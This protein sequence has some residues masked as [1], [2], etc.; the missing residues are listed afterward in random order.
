MFYLNFPAFVL[1][2]TSW[3]LALGKHRLVFSQKL[4]TRKKISG[5][6]FSLGFPLFALFFSLSLQSSLNSGLQISVTSVSPTIGISFLSKISILCLNLHSSH[7]GLESAS[8][9]VARP[10]MQLTTIFASFSQESQLCVP[11]YPVLE[12][13]F[14]IFFP[15]S[16]LFLEKSKTGSNHSV[17]QTDRLRAF[18][19][20]IFAG[21]LGYIFS[22]T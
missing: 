13:L 10:L 16:W 4:K 22:D 12:Q 11:C 5:V 21:A 9:Q 15:V 1:Y 19:W 2:L 6:L 7:W 3:S 14:H 17:S 20:V 8:T 18:V